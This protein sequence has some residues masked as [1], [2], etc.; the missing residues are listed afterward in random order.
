M[1]LEIG[2]QCGQGFGVLGNGGQRGTRVGIA[3]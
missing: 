1:L 2:D 3:P